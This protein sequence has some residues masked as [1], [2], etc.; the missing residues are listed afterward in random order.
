MMRLYRKQRH[1]MDSKIVSLWEAKK[2]A[3]KK[4]RKPYLPTEERLRE[5]EEDV[6]KLIDMTMLLENTVHHQEQLITKL[7]HLLKDSPLVS[8]EA[9]LPSREQELG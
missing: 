8:S 5:L 7:L 6:L 9:E 3:E 1:I 4:K 2:Q